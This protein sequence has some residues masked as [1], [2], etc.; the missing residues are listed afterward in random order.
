MHGFGKQIVAFGRFE[1]ELD[2]MRAGVLCLFDKACG[3]I[4]IAAGA[5]GDEQVAGA[6]RGFDFIH[7]VGE[8][9]EPDD[10]GPHETGDVTGKAGDCGGKVV[11]P[12]A[13]GCRNWCTECCG[14]FAVHVKQLSRTGTLVQVIDV[15]RHQQEIA[16]KFALQPRQCDMRGVRLHVGHAPAAFVV[17]LMDQARGS[18]LETLRCR[19]V[20]VVD[21]RPDAV[22]VAK[23][24]D[25]GFCRN[26]GA[27]EDD[28]PPQFA[29]AR[30]P[31]IRRMEQAMNRNGM[32]PKRSSELM[33]DADAGAGK[34]AR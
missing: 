10:V 25:T 34:T 16:G 24:V 28:D 17:E 9:T 5:D 12:F 32:I 15:L 6:D 13:L 18:S 20:A 30:R 27:G 2:G 21:P 7:P 31:A 23:R 1:I 29:Q 11:M 33:L 26:A 14:Q 3:G 22:L 19:H 8:F 4:D